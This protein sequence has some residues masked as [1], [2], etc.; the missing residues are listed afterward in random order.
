VRPAPFLLTRPRPLA[1]IPSMTR[2][3]F[4]ECSSARLSE[5]HPLAKTK[6]KTKT[7]KQLTTKIAKAD[8]PPT[9]DARL[10]G[11]GRCDQPAQWQDNRRDL[12]LCGVHMERLIGDGSHTRTGFRKIRPL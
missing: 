7:P 3:R 1:T 6:T 2:P 4:D 12:N 5:D 11:G 9:C 10:P 8:A